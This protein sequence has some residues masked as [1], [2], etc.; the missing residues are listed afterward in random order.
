MRGIPTRTSPVPSEVDGIPPFIDDDR[1]AS[2]TRSDLVRQRRLSPALLVALAAG[3]VVAL[4]VAAGDGSDAPSASPATTTTSAPAPAP[5][6]AAAGT[7][8]RAE[9]GVTLDPSTDV[10]GRTVRLRVSPTNGRRPQLVALTP[11][12]RGTV[13]A[14]PPAAR[15]ELDPHGLEADLDGRGL[16]L[17][18]PDA[19]PVDVEPSARA[20]SPR[21]A[22]S[23]SRRT[24]SSARC[25]PTTRSARCS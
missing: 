11:D 21:S 8:T 2:S 16:L 4:I 10:L 3:V 9:P 14:L 12:G 19:V 18:G 22:G 23:A 6:Q 15:F 25:S 1:P 5:S 24:A 20:S 17:V 7:G 13:R